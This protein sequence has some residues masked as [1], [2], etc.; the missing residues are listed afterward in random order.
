MTSLTVRPSA[1]LASLELTTAERVLQAFLISKVN[2]NTREAYRR[3]LLQ[4]LA[5]CSRYEL[6]LLN[7]SRP[8]LD[9]FRESLAREQ[10]SPASIA[11]KLSA[12][13]AFYDY[14]VKAGVVRESPAANIERP[15][16]GTDTPRTG[17]DREEALL[18]IA[19]AR[20]AGSAHA[21]L[22][23][24][25]LL[26]CLRVSEALSLNVEDLSREQGVT[27]VTVK[28]KGGRRFRVVLS[29]EALEL[30]SPALRKGA[31]AIVRGERG[32]R[33]D[34]RKA[35]RVVNSLAR[36]I[37]LGRDLCPHDLR[38]AA[39]TNALIAGAPLEAVQDMAGHS[40]PV[41]T[42]RYNRARFQL[43]NS[44]AHNLGAYLLPSK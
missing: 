24:L 7:L 33:W 22:V 1:S 9:L 23:A 27:V 8:H 6:D 16:V 21:A 2:P 36:S 31:G 40:S 30:L 29:A 3:D 18:L 17:L 32:A 25:C 12:V 44:A 4:L 41:T 37:H 19:A 43:A 38:H 34:R 20:E 39:I 28:R 42:Q 10:L 13:A 11:R 14:A 26:A 5:Y 15:K 35:A